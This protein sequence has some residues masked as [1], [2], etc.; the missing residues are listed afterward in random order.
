MIYPFLFTGLVSL[1]VSLEASEIKENLDSLLSKNQIFFS[2]KLTR[3]FSAPKIASRAGTTIT[4]TEISADGPQGERIEVEITSPVERDR[5]DAMAKTKAMVVEGTY[6]DQPSP[7]EG[8]VTNT[9]SCPAK[10]KP[11]RLE[12]KNSFA[13]APALVGRTTSK[14]VWGNCLPGAQAQMGSIAFFFDPSRKRLI[15]ISIFQSEQRFSQRTVADAL[16]GVKFAP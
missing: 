2:P 7:Y 16:L 4:F 13:L 6:R 9:V 1:S 15:R 12:L 14:H 11:I 10:F 8:E 5:A 3:E